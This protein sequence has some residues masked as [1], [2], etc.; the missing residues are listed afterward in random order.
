[1][2]M[3][4]LV[5]GGAGYIGTHTA[6][7]LIQE[8]HDVVIVDNFSNS[9][10]GALKRVNEIVGKQVPFY[11]VDATDKEALSKIF[12][13]HHIDAVI[14]FAAYKAVGQSVAKPITYY[15][16]NLDSLITVC[17]IMR[18][19][20]VTRF[21][22]SS[23]ATVYGLP[24]H[25]PITE[26]F[27][28]K[29]T[30]PYGQTK[31]MCEQILKDIAHANA[32][33]QV[34]I[35]RYFNPIGAHE[36]GKIGESP[37]GIPNNIFP[38]IASVAVGKLSEVKVF[39][40]DYDTPDGTGIRDYIHVVDLAKGHLAALEHM[41]PGYLV[42]NLGTGKGTSVLELINAY[43][44]ACGKK[45][46]YKVVE[47]RPGDI[48]QCYADASKAKRELGWQAEKTIEDACLD[49]W[50]WQSANPGGFTS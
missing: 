24:E 31:L 15:R 21:V 27:P 16:N 28:L 9:K 20:K 22:F 36:S 5:T 2:K 12:E 50:R 29:A 6:V 46:P 3:S 8:G 14:H 32:D 7:E 25:V 41:K 13:E 40:D 34:T 33:W 1:M 30:N 48:T 38:Y 23:S 18:R 42:Y 37:N 43:S 10:P 47:R 26:D 39:G 4:V 35:L 49:S 19:H 45:L 11:N 44:K 17:E